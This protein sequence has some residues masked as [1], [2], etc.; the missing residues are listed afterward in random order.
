MLASA[1]RRHVCNS[2]FENFKQRLLYSLTAYISC[3]R[4]VFGFFGD[5]IYFVN[6]DNT[7]LGFFYIIICS[8]KQFKQNIFNVFAYISGF[9]KRCGICYGKRHIE[10]FCQC[11]SQ[12]CL[13]GSCRSYHYDIALLNFNIVIIFAKIVNSLVVI[14]DC[15]RQSFFGFVLVYNVITQ[16]LAYFLRL[17]QSAAACLVFFVF[18]SFYALFYYI[19]AELY[20]FIAYIHIGPCYETSYLSLRFTAE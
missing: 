14:V 3:N 15:N 9:C 2:S 6:V 17:W 8:L 12:Q 1:L 18:F 11:L 16:S 20:T 13:A 5:F 19:S 7:L 10:Y 4:Y